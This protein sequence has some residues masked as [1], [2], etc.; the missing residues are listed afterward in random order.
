MTIAGDER[1][2]ELAV[3][4]AHFAL[5]S[6]SL[7]KDGRA[8]ARILDPLHLFPVNV[9]IFPVFWPTVIIAPKTKRM[10]RG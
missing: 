7:S 3:R 9:N 5:A 2:K 6:Q 4:G 8:A 1:T 10:F